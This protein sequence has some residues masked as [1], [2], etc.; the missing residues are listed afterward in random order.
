MG[1]DLSISIAL[2]QLVHRLETQLPNEFPQIQSNPLL[3]SEHSSFEERLE[4]VLSKKRKRVDFRSILRREVKKT[5]PEYSEDDNKFMEDMQF[6][7]RIT[8]FTNILIIYE[9]INH[10]GLGKALAKSREEV[11]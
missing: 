2:D 4:K 10:V 1:H 8:P 5:L 11:C 6:R 3:H 7:K 9:K